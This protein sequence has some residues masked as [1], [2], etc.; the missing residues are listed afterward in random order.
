MSLWPGVTYLMKSSIKLSW[1][2]GLEQ[3]LIKD[4]WKAIAG[5]KEK[6]TMPEI[7]F[8]ELETKLEQKAKIFI[9]ACEI[10][11][12]A[13]FSTLSDIEKSILDYQKNREEILKAKPN[14]EAKIQKLREE[15]T[16]LQNQNNALSAKKQI[17]KANEE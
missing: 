15:F 8:A 14:K 4:N 17:K 13:D 16:K 2:R 5:E 10:S 7:N 11:L 3:N 9:E 6:P 12:G 1:R